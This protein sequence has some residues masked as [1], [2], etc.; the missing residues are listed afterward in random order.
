M[1]DPKTERIFKIYTDKSCL[2]PYKKK[3]VP[4]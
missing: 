1:E 3:K 2:A 4:N